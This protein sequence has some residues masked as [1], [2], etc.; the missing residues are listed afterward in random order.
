MPST[1]TRPDSGHELVVVANRL[2][3]DAKTLPDGA[4]EWV[5]SPGGLVTAMES[6]MRTVRSSS[7]RRRDA[8]RE[9]SPEPVPC[10]RPV[11]RPSHRVVMLRSSRRGATNE[12]LAPRASYDS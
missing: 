12:G 2:P 5:T 11:A 6:V 7:T 9:R 3:V 4:T 1:D 10:T 8:V